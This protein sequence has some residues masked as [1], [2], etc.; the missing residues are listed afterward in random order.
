MYIVHSIQEFLSV[1]V[2]LETKK[3]KIKPTLPD[4]IL[5]GGWQW[6]ERVAVILGKSVM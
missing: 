6:K 5:E 4:T 3:K 2:D 1:K